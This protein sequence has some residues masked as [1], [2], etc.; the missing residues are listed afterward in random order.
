[1]AAGDLTSGVIGIDVRDAWAAGLGSLRLVHRLQPNCNPKRWESPGRD[2][3]RFVHNLSEILV[4]LG[5]LVLA[6][7]CWDGAVQV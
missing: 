1:M 6:G 7:S 3:M 2:R 4:T 5:F